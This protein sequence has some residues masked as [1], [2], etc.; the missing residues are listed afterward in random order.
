MNTTFFSLIL[1]LQFLI[2]IAFSEES[3]THDDKT[4]R[5]VKYLRNYDG[6]TI[7]FDIKEVHPLLGKK[8]SIRVSGVDTPEIK[9]KNKCEK[10]KAKKAKRAVASVLS[11]AKKIDLENIERGKYF[12]I[13]ADVKFDGKSL[14]KYLLDQGL[15]YPYNGGRKTKVNWCE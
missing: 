10:K 15:G 3:C 6:D 9:T 4:F 13:V 7:T 2:N 8:I 12:R 11:K 1:F 5:C 14:S